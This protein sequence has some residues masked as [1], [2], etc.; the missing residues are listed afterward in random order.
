MRDTQL[1]KSPLRQ[2]EASHKNFSNSHFN[3]I[4]NLEPVPFYTRIAGMTPEDPA[5]IHLENESLKLMVSVL[6]AIVGRFRLDLREQRHVAAIRRAFGLEGD[7][8]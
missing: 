2:Q 5:D 6:L 1:R 4:K 7:A 3:I 8:Q